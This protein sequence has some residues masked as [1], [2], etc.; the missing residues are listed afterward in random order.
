MN[1]RSF[2][3]RNA[4]GPSAQT[5]AAPALQATTQINNA[6]SRHLHRERDF[7]VGYGNSSGYASDRR[8]TTDW[9]QPLFRCA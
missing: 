8:Y 7:G 2:E 4:F 5:K 3:A 6:Q 1:V 9:A